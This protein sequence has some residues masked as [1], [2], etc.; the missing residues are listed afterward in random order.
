MVVGEGEGGVFKVMM[1]VGFFKVVGVSRK[2]WDTYNLNSF[3]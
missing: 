1:R 3:W 2:F